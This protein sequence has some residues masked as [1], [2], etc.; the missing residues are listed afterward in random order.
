MCQ[1]VCNKWNLLCSLIY[2]RVEGVL[3][4][5]TDVKVAVPQCTNTVTSKTPEIL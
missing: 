5:F 1:M 3:G 4:S 2:T